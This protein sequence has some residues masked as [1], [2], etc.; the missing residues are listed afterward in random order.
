MSRVTL[1]LA[2]TDFT[3]AVA[4]D[5]AGELVF[6]VQNPLYGATG[7]GTT[8]DTAAIQACINAASVT[9]GNVVYFP[10]GVYVIS[11]PLTVSVSGLTLLG[12]GPGATMGGAGAGSGTF[13]PGTAGTITGTLLTGAVIAPSSSFAK[14]S[15]NVASCILID[16]T[17]LAAQQDRV[18][19]ERLNFYGAN[20]GTTTCHGI[21]AYGNVSGLRITNCGFYVFYSTGSNAVNFAEDGSSNDTD[22]CLIDTC[23]AQFIGKDGFHLGPFGDGT[24]HNCHS[25]TVGGYGFYVS[26]ASGYSGGSGG[27]IRLL[28]CRGDLSG[29]DG[30][31][32]NVSCGQYL[33]MIQVSNCTTQRNYNNGF[34][35]AALASTETCPVYL[36]NCVA[37]GDGTDGASSGYRVNGPV[38]ASLLNCAC[39]LNNDVD[40]I[41]C[42]IY[43]ITTADT[44]QP[45]LLVTVI[46]G[47]Y[48]AYTAWDNVANAP[49]YSSVA[50]VWTLAGGQMNY[51]STLVL[52]SSL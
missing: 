44:T 25:Q 4:A 1:P 40:S 5:L 37:Q 45:P 50:D 36:S 12:G 33:G 34:H 11:A 21:T 47:F 38:I 7:N 48:N 15:A 42:P 10:P 51:N 24:A 19:V 3:A 8:D 35:I 43:G 23:M 2:G 6:N 49:S 46:G 22:G 27:N 41:K 20:A 52:K 13:T 31:Y 32:L 39:H 28:N 18:T 9:T 14:G 16:A 29:L 17:I 26:N 30:F